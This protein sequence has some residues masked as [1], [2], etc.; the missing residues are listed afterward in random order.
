MDT[1]IQVI[2]IQRLLALN[3]SLKEL[4]DVKKGEA[5]RKLKFAHLKRSKGGCLNVFSCLWDW[6]LSKIKKVWTFI[7]SM[8]AIDKS[9]PIYKQGTL[10]N[11]LFKRMA[12]FTFGLV[13]SWLTFFFVYYQMDVKKMIVVLLVAPMTM[14]LSWYLAF[15]SYFQC[16]VLLMLPVIFS[17]KGRYVILFQVGLLLTIGPIDN[18]SYNGQEMIRSAMC[19]QEGEGPE[20]ELTRTVRQYMNAVKNFIMKMMK[21]IKEI[22]AFITEHLSKAI[23]AMK[24][25]AEALNS[26]ARISGNFPPLHHY[27]TEEAPK[28]Q[29][30]CRNVDFLGIHKSCKIIGKIGNFSFFLC[31]LFLDKLKN[32]ICPIPTIICR[33]IIEKFQ[34]LR[35]QMAK[36]IDKAIADI[37]NELFFDVDVNYTFKYDVHQSKK[38]REVVREVVDEFENIHWYLIAAMKMFTLF[39]WLVILLCFWTIFKSLIYRWKYLRNDGFDNTYLNKEVTQYDRIRALKD[40]ETVFPLTYYDRRRYIYPIDLKMTKTELRKLINGLVQYTMALIQCVIVV[41]IDYLLYFSMKSIKDM[42]EM[43]KHIPFLINVEPEIEKKGFFKGIKN[44]VT[45]AIVNMKTFFKAKID[46]CKPQPNQPDY[47]INQRILIFMLLAFITIWT[48]AYGLRTRH[49]ICSL[50]YPER[51]KPRAIWLYHTI[52]AQRGDTIDFIRRKMERQVFGNK[53]IEHHTVME[54]FVAK[55]PMFRGIMK[56]LGIYKQKQYCI[57][58]G[59]TRFDEDDPNFKKCDTQNCH[60]LYCLNCFNQFNNMCSLCMKPIDYAE[61]GDVSEERDSEEQ[62][63]KEGKS[64]DNAIDEYLE[65]LKMKAKDK[66]KMDRKIRSKTKDTKNRS[67]TKKES[68]VKKESKTKKQKEAK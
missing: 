25:I 14:A 26:M 49:W 61:L 39:E 59:K 12:G 2:K 64:N 55:F 52:L 36:K 19:W 13:L 46:D 8:F 63:L 29:E 28:L 24:K 47:D 4:E 65:Q 40:E 17:S 3:N 57:E 58:C 16:I 6:I 7:K 45:E 37:K 32:K 44:D 48:D 15:S 21:N 60:G 50:Y 66:M 68:K 53:E 38:Y 18:I 31:N 5:L 51:I 35:D 62:Q 11:K 33:Y 22:L 54:R 34:E 41:F 67:K 27:C 43:M 42:M 10:E 30:K 56:I 9:Q 20:T 23:N 1:V